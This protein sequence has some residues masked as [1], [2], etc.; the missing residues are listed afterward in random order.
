MITYNEVQHL[1][2]QIVQSINEFDQNL[3]STDTKQ[4][5]NIP[6][7]TNICSSIEILE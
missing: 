1:N 4:Q 2:E 3:T 5:V 6:H 7:K